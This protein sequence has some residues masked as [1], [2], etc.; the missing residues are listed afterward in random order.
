VPI[1]SPVEKEVKGAILVRGRPGKKELTSLEETFTR[2]G[3][4]KK[5]KGRGNLL[6]WTWGKIVLERQREVFLEERTFKSRQQRIKKRATTSREYHQNAQTKKAKIQVPILGQGKRTREP[7]TGRKN[8]PQT[9]GWKKKNQ[10]NSIQGVGQQY[11]DKT[12]EK[13]ARLIP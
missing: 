9:V 6:R 7:K 8:S 1:H 5:K 13:E 2:L 10:G 3:Q 12:Y 4:T 11:V